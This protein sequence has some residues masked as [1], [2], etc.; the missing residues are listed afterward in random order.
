MKTE[1]YLT[2]YTK[3]KSRWSKDLDL[4]GQ[5]FRRKRRRLFLQLAHSKALLKKSLSTS[6]G[7]RH[8]V[9]SA[10]LKFCTRLIRKY[11]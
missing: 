9:H 10:T 4:K 5:T 2:P 11:G 3:T 7:R 8:W 6:R 1:P